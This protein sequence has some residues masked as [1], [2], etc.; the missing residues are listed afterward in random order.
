VDYAITIIR[1]LHLFG[2]RFLGEKSRHVTKIKIE[3][4][5][6]KKKKQRIRNPRKWGGRRWDEMRRENARGYVYIQ[7][8]LEALE[9]THTA[10]GN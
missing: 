9:E 1:L 5:T 2:N 3:T 7:E 10:F 6:Q 4:N 8:K